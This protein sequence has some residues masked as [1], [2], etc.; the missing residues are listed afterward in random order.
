MHVQPNPVGTAVSASYLRCSV[1]CALR[2][3]I[4]QDGSVWAEGRRAGMVWRFVQ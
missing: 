3:V 4:I 2:A 1:V